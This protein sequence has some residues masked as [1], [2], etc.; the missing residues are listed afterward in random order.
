MSKVAIK[1][2]MR[3]L[4]SKFDKKFQWEVSQIANKKFLCVML[5]G[6]L[7]VKL[8]HLKSLNKNFKNILNKKLEKKFLWVLICIKPKS[9]VIPFS[10][11]C[12]CVWVGGCGGGGGVWGKKISFTQNGQKCILILEFLRPEDIFEI[13]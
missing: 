6:G 9:G 10:V 13:L 1:C 4:E 12:V 8:N 11:V 3:C 7:S 2:H 5:L